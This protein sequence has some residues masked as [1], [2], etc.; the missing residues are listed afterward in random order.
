MDHRSQIRYAA[1]II[2]EHESFKNMFIPFSKKI[3]RVENLAQLAQN[4]KKRQIRSA[5]KSLRIR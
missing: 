4:Y 3:W 1:T 2:I 5:P